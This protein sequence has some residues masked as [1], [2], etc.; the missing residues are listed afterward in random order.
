MYKMCVASARHAERETGIRGVSGGVAKGR[1]MCGA[2]VESAI[3]RDSDKMATSP[4]TWAPLDGTSVP[5][6]GF[7]RVF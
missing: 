2:E 6:L 7:L 3:A 1:V 5:S 4:S